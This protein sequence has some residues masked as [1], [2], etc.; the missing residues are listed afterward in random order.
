MR[1]LY[2]DRTTAGGRAY[3]QRLGRSQ[4]LSVESEAAVWYNRRN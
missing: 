3:A 2:Y 4:V 1:F